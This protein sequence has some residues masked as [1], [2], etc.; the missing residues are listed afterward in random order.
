MRCNYYCRYAGKY[1]AKKLICAS[2]QHCS[3][4]TQTRSARFR[5]ILRAD[6]VELLCCYSPRVGLQSDTGIST[7]EDMT[8]EFLFAEERNFSLI[9]M[10]NDLNKARSVIRVQLLP[11]DIMLGLNRR[12]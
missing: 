3:Q 9:N 10:I 5:S 6:C 2:K 7:V 1:L 8:S 11:R 4:A 12:T